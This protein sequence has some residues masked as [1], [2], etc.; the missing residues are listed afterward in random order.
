M[1]HTQHSPCPAFPPS[2]P[3]HSQPSES[4]ELPKPGQDSGQRPGGE[5]P[6]IGRAHSFVYSTNTDLL[7]TVLMLRDWVMNEGE[8]TCLYG[9]CLLVRADRQQ[10]RETGGFSGGDQFFRG[11]PGKR[12]RK[13]R[14]REGCALGLDRSV[15]VG[16]PLPVH[17]TLGKSV[18]YKEA[19]GPHL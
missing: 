6:A 5:S 18:P 4:P 12:D 8:K 19:S 16:L 3:P 17:A 7:S 14:G 2:Q 1:C 11:K 10:I 15:S 9:A 13:W